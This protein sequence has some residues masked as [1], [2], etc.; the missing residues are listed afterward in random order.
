MTES[1][2]SISPPTNRPPATYKPSST[3]TTKPTENIVNG[4]KVLGQDQ[5]LKLMLS[6]LENQDPLEPVKD[7]DFIAQMA[8]FSSLEQ[9]SQLNKSISE[10]LSRQESAQLHDY[11]GKKVKINTTAGVVSG[12]VTEIKN[13]GEESKVVV[14]GFEYN[15]KF[16]KSV[17]LASSQIKVLKKK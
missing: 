6:Q 10:F 3:I 2:N 16:I 4:K 14:N 12:V 13:L 17:E 7:T 5:F 9:Q 8:Q 1:I 11:L 15:P